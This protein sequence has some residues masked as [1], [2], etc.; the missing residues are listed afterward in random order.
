M[1]ACVNVFCDNNKNNND[2][3]I[4]FVKKA[5]TKDYF[6]TNTTKKSNKKRKNEMKCPSTFSPLFFLSTKQLQPA[7]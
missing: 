2:K 7:K 4:R 3:M 1:R 5:L 6:T